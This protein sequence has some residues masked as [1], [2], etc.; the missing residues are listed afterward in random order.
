MAVLCLT[1]CGIFQLKKPKNYVDLLKPIAK[2]YSSL[3]LFSQSWCFYYSE[4]LLVQ[5]SQTLS[6]IYIANK[7]MNYGN[8][9]IYMLKWCITIITALLTFFSFFAIRL[10]QKIPS[11]F[12]DICLY[13]EI[14]CMLANYRYRLPARRFIQELFQGVDYS[15]VS[16]L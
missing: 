6:V 10:K 16:F 2:H 15:Q 8:L 1:G 7:W 5:V 3:V 14:S 13:H 4:I 9:Y 12:Q 11:A